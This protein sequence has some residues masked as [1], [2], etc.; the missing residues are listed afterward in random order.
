MYLQYM[1]TSNISNQ[2]YTE[3]VNQQQISLVNDGITLADMESLY[4]DIYMDKV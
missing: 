2:Q 4:R 3:H 1:P